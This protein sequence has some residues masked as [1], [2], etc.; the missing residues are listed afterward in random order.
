M[1]EVLSLLKKGAMAFGKQNQLL[2]QSGMDVFKKE[3]TNKVVLFWLLLEYLVQKQK[4]IQTFE[5]G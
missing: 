2:S 1:L 3:I 4:W 5:C